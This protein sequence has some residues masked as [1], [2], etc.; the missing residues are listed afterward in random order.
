MKSA[1]AWMR[2]RNVRTAAL[3]SYR[4]EVSPL[5]HFFFKSGFYVAS[6]AAAIFYGVAIAILPPILLLYVSLPILLLVA[7][8]L[9]AL[10]DQHRISLK[11]LRLCFFAF[12]AA[13]FLWPDYLAID[14]PGFAWISL[15][16]LCSWAMA[17]SLAMSISTSSELRHRIRSVIGQTRPFWI[18]VAL[19]FAAQW[20]TIVLSESPASSF[21]RSLNQVFIWGVPLLAAVCVFEEFAQVRR[22]IGF[23]LIAGA[24]NCVISALEFQNAGLLWE[25]HIPSFLTVEADV[26]QRIM[27]GAVRDGQ[28]RVVSVFSVSLCLAEFLSFLTPFALRRAFAT[29]RIGPILF[30]TIFDLVLWGA[31]I[32]TRS[33]LGIIGWLASHSVFMLLWG[34]KRWTEKPRD[35]FGPAISLAFPFAAS[36]LFIS[37]FTVDAVRVRTI[38]G[39][40]T[41]FSDRAREAQYALFW[42]KFFHNPLGYGSGR[43][44]AVLDYQLP[45]GLVTVDSYFITTGLDYGIIGLVSYFGMFLYAFNL[46]GKTYLDSDAKDGDIA[47][48]LACA[49]AVLFMIR[50]VLSQ[51]DNTPLIFITFGAAM[52]LYARNRASIQKKKNATS[53]A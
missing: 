9:W 29:N 30:W 21:N 4:Q 38:G 43:S 20:L 53:A 36:A 40:S 12:S 52:S 49:I 10:P 2:N 15:R 48:A 11:P 16:R 8:T 24:V 13:I 35:L 22:W 45:G 33:R 39:G 46:M 5:R 32:L 37:M 47:L 31:I 18:M 3:P 44:G 34:W 28:Y 42:P 25:H 23:L 51:S 1:S 6:I 26:L 41:G 17:A 50:L 27:S 19:Y 7:G 14:I